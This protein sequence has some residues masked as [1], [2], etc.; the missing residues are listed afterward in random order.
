MVVS[1]RCLIDDGQVAPGIWAHVQ[2]CLGV[3]GANLPCLKPLF[4]DPR[5]LSS[6]H[7]PSTN[8][9]TNGN[10]RSSRSVRGS[11]S[12][13]YKALEG[14]EPS[15]TESDIGLVGIQQWTSTPSFPGQSSGVHTTSV[16]QGGV[17][18]SVDIERGLSLNE[19][20]I[21][22]DVDVSSTHAT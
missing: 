22:R 3:V 12:D 6:I 8:A 17:P 11:T 15:L 7:R 19:I 21:T 20:S 16:A 10:I 13:Q 5:S 14:K 2:L 4:Q 18:R 1:D 9:P